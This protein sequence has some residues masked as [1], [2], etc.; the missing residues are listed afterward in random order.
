MTLRQ[1]ERLRKQRNQG[2]RWFVQDTFTLLFVAAVIYTL[3][4]LLISMKEAL[5]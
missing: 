2:I 5:L 1:K 4:I 3:F